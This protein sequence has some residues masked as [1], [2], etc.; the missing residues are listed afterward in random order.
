MTSQDNIIDANNTVLLLRELIATNREQ[1]A[2]LKALSAQMQ[3]YNAEFRASMIKEFSD[4]KDSINTRLNDFENG[5]DGRLTGM[6]AEI[7]QINQRLT[8]IEHDITGLYHWDYWLLS[9]ILF[10]AALPHLADI[11]KAIPVAITET[12]RDVMAIFGKG[13]T[14]ND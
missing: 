12:I 6:H 4:F 8:G 5:V 2:E 14:S 7:G 1:I 11:I 10:F 13:K 3:K 9:F